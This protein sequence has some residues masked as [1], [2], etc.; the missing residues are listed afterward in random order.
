MHKFLSWLRFSSVTVFLFLQQNLT[1]PLHKKSR[2]TSEICHSK[3]HSNSRGH[4]SSGSRTNSK[5]SHSHL[6]R[7]PGNSK[8]V[9]SESKTTSSHSSHHHHHHGTHAN[10]SSKPHN[11]CSPSKQG[12]HESGDNDSKSKDHVKFRKRLAEITVKYLTPYFKS[13]KF[14]S[15]VS[16]LRIDIKVIIQAITIHTYTNSPFSPV[17]ICLFM[18]KIIK[19]SKFVCSHCRIFSRI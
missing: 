13:G 16:F 7:L 6:S 18:G 3:K 17:F 15:K 10:T 14:A 12:S 4:H 11:K 8:K 2:Q 19:W 1:E 5:S 9:G